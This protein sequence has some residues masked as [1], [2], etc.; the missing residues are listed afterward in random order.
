MWKICQNGKLKNT[1]VGQLCPQ[2]ASPTHIQF[3]KGVCCGKKSIVV[4]HV[5]VEKINEV[6]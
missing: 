5:V 1:S 3:W 6:H 4:T 2:L